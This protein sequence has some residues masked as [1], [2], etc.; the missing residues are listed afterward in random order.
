MKIGL[1]CPIFHSK[2]IASVS[3]SAW[4]NELSP[5]DLRADTLAQQSMNEAPLARK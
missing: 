2:F 1:F 4:P 5:V 3:F